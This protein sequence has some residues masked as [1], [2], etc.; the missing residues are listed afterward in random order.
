MMRGVLRKVRDSR[1]AGTAVKRE[2][3]AVHGHPVF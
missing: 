3:G 1:A 2:S